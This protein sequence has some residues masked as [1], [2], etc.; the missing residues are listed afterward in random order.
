MWGGTVIFAS[1][2]VLVASAN[3]TTLSGGVASGRPDGGSWRLGG[4]G[5]EF[6]FDPENYGY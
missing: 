3:V 1:F 6:L 5:A 4:G 2:G